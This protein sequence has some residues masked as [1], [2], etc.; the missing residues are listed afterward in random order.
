[1]DTKSIRVLMQSNKDL[2]AESLEQE[3]EIISLE[4]KLHLKTSELEYY[5]VENENERARQSLIITE[6]RDQVW[7]L[8]GGKVAH[9]DS[10]HWMLKSDDEY[11]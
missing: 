10:N 2:V 1:M 5:R 8:K 4:G 11:E 7:R 6:L 3:E 9:V